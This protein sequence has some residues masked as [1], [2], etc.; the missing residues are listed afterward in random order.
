MKSVDLSYK[1]LIKCAQKCYDSSSST[2][3]ESSWLRKPR[4]RLCPTLVALTYNL[5]KVA[6]ISTPIGT[7]KPPLF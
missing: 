3:S 4:R 1:D 5:T 6:T 7:A 2:N